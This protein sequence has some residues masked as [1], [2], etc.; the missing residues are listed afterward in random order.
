MNLEL[1]I[2]TKEA[3]Q[4]KLHV[5]LVENDIVQSQ[6]NGGANYVHNY[7]TRTAMTAAHM[8]DDYSFEA[9]SIK[10]IPLSLE[11]PSAVRDQN[12]LAIIAYVTYEG[13][14]KGS[15][16]NADYM[17]FGNIVDNVIYC[18]VGSLVDYKYEE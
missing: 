2:A 9:N 7:V 6:T 12:N 4:C 16:P 15:V 17:N 5:C 18:P 11:V 13:S 3:K 14:Y 1:F 10:Y 8:G